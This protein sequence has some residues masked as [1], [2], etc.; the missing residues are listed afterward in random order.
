MQA[1]QQIYQRAA[2]RKGGE[3]VLRQLL[4]GN[5]KS[6]QQLADI[7]DNRYLA[8]MTKA[9]F[10][11]GFVWKIVEHKW[12]GFEETFWGF[13]VGRCAFMSPDDEDAICADTRIV[14]NRQKILTVPHNAVMIIE[15]RKEHG[16]F[17]RFIADWSTQDFIGLL[18][19]LGKHGARLGGMT[20]QYFLRVIGKDGFVLSRDGVH[21]LIQAGVI[22]KPPTGKAARRKVQQAYN[23]WQQESGMGLSELSRV[24]ALSIDAP[25][26]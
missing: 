18:D 5:I 4:T 14:R 6:P 17:G 15:T 8:E 1:F 21:A 13:D 25:K 26:D 10:K 11:A 16:S 7:S 2:A 3:V 24:L 12:A 20:A 23:Q 9:V 22:D 19:Y